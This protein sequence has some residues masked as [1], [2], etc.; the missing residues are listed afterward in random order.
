MNGWDLLAR[1]GVFFSQMRTTTPFGWMLGLMM[2]LTVLWTVSMYVRYILPGR[3]WSAPPWKRALEI[4][5]VTLF[6]CPICLACLTFLTLCIARLLHSTVSFDLLLSIFVAACVPCF[7]GWIGYTVRATERKVY[8]LWPILHIALR[9][10]TT[11]LIP[12][13]LHIAG[14]LPYGKVGILSLPL[15]LSL[16]IFAVAEIHNKPET[17]QTSRSW[18][19]RVG[20]NTIVFYPPDAD[21]AQIET[22]LNGCDVTLERVTCLLRA[23]PLNFK[24]RVFLFPNQQELNQ[25]AR[26]DKVVKTSFA[27]A[28]YTSIVVVL[29]RWEQL[30][31]TVAHEFCHVLRMRIAPH[32]TGFLDEGLACYVQNQICPNSRQAAISHSLSVR[33]LAHYYLFYEF[34]YTDAPEFP[35]RQNYAHAHAFAEFL[36]TRNGM[37]KYLQ[38][39]REASS[40]TKK[41]AGE[42]MAN[43]IDHVYGTTLTALEKE[44]RHSWQPGQQVFRF[45]A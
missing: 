24:V 22:I 30:S 31:G 29:D 4:A 21:A 14:L 32:L 36:I 43:A 19:R 39:C 17:F 35:A 1:P 34:Q 23:K 37:E 2:A 3:R 8:C 5:S 42:L 13:G 6:I 27:Y 38:L 16:W 40:D 9:L 25:V 33:T 11:A 18:R 44:W 15:V 12:F 45:E 26:E 20:K 7:L 28:Y 10:W 41:E